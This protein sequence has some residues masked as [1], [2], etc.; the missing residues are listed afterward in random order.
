LF[1]PFPILFSAD[2]DRRYAP[3]TCDDHPPRAR[4]TVKHIL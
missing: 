4:K 3:E 2:A 1:Q